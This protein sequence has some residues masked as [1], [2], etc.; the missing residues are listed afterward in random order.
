MSMRRPRGGEQPPIANPVD[1]G[2]EEEGWEEFVAEEK[3]GPEGEVEKERWCFAWGRQGQE[4]VVE[5]E[6]EE[7]EEEGEEEEAVV[8]PLKEKISQKDRRKKKE[9]C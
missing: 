8:Q 2:E 3:E 7:E 6:E 5:E 4:E 9:D 1:I